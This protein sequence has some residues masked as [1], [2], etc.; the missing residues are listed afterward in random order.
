MGSRAKERNGLGAAFMSEHRR[1]RGVTILIVAVDQATVSEC[2]MASLMRRQAESS[3]DEIARLAYWVVADQHIDLR[4]HLLL[5]GS[6]QLECAGGSADL[7]AGRSRLG[8]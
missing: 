8:N 3:P 6:Q 1:E 5:N 4:P 2:H 7:V